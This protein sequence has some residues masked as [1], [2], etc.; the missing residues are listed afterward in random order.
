M[1]PSKLTNFLTFVALL[2]LCLAR[3]K[4]LRM[5]SVSEVAKVAEVFGLHERDDC[6]ITSYNVHY[7]DCNGESLPYS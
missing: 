3:A 7:D 5:S 4:P 1:A 6:V 2:P